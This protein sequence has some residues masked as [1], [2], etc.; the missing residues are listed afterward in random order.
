MSSV[1]VSSLSSDRSRLRF[2]PE[3]PGWPVDPPGRRVLGRRCTAGGVLGGL[4]VTLSDAPS[5][6]LTPATFCPPSSCWTDRMIR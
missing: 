3:L 5:S 2:S 6:A 4:T 1:S